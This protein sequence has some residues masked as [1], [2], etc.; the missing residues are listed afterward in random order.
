MSV[1]DTVLPSYDEDLCVLAR[2]AS[3][4]VHQIKQSIIIGKLVRNERV[5]NRAREKVI[6]NYDTHR[7]FVCELIVGQGSE[8]TGVAISCTLQHKNHGHGIYL[9]NDDEHYAKVEDILSFVNTTTILHTIEDHL[10]YI[11]QKM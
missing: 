2:I 5:N 9:F 4:I 3:E 11:I 7:R 6:Y 10:K 1:V 8:G